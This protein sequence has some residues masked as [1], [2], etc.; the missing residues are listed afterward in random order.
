MTAPVNQ[1]HDLVLHEPPP[2]RSIGPFPPA[3]LFFGGPR[4]EAAFGGEAG[5]VQGPS[6]TPSELERISQ[7]IKQRLIE[8]AHRFSTATADR[9]AAL[10][11]DQYHLAAD[12][13]DHPK[14][15]SK[16]GRIM[17]ASAVN[18][19]KQMSF[20]DYARDVFGPFYLSDEEDIGHEQICFRIVR[21]GRREDVGS[22]HRDS[23]FWDYF[24]FAVPDGISRTKVWVPV[25]GEPDKSGLLL[26]PGSHRRPGGF[27]TE[28]IDGKLAF[29]PEVDART[30]DLHRYLGRPGDPVLFNYDVLHVGAL[31]RGEQSRV[32]FEITIMYGTQCA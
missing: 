19:I 27:R 23:W 4:S 9:I 1:W 24:D 28:T 10:P 31:N 17:P 22:L 6:F 13:R 18:E 5:L 8:N 12:P 26:A 7:L 16:L 25:C 11:L 3:S 20:F 2:L 30:L 29:I 21:P 32:S 15:L 14:L